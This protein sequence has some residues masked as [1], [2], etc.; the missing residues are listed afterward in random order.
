MAVSY[1]FQSAKITTIACRK[2]TKIKLKYMKTVVIAKY[3]NVGSFK[4]ISNW[5]ENCILS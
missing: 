2:Q 4:K 3:E 5:P 1:P